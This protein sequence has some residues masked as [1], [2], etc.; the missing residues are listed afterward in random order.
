[1]HLGLHLATYVL[2]RCLVPPQDQG[3]EQEG[4]GNSFQPVQEVAVRPKGLWALADR[5][6]YRADARIAVRYDKFVVLTEEDR[7][8]WEGLDNIEVIPNAR[9]FAFES[10]STCSAH[11]VLAVGR[12]NYQKGFDMLLEAWKKIDTSGWMLRIAGSGDDLGPV[13]ANVITGPSADIR[14]EYI[15][16]S[17]FAMSSR[18]EG[19]PMVLL[20][21]QAA[22]LPIVSF[23]CKCGPK[24]IVEPGVS[25]YLVAEGDTSALAAKIK[26]LMDDEELRRKM[27]SAAFKASERY[28]IQ[29]IM[30][31]WADLFQRLS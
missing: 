20:E 6:R 29:S 11:Q 30:N 28:D 2:Q 5:W 8:Y 18:Y 4:V 10:P 22:G 14:K 16:S 23:Q 12:Y 31:K 3:W 27:G 25:G 7:G 19:L 15:N 9:S 17:I 24:D 26:E 13:P 1:A 21:A